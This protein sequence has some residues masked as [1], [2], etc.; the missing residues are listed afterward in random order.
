VTKHLLVS[1]EKI[2]FISDVG[3]R[4]LLLKRGEKKSR[5]TREVLI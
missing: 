3:C 2:V 5:R 1:D 4:Q